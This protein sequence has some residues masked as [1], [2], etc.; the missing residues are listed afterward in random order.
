[1]EEISVNADFRL[2]PCAIRAILEQQFP[3]LRI[4]AVDLFEDGCDSV[5]VLADKTWMFLFARRKSAEAGLLRSMRLLGG[6]HADL[7][8]PV[9]RP[10]FWGVPGEAF[11]FHF[12]GYR[13]LPGISADRQELPSHRRAACA[14][15]LGEFLAALHR[16]PAGRLGA[17]GFQPAAS[18]DHAEALLTEARQLAPR[19]LTRLP[20]DLK[21]R[22]MPFLDGKVTR[23]PPPAGQLVLTHGDLQA[24]HIL[25]GP[26][27]DVC[28]IIDFG[29][30]GLSDP[31]R[32]YAGLC[33]WQGWDFAGAAL[34]ASRR[35]GDETIESRIRF[36]AKCLGLSGLA[37]ASSDDPV[38]ISACRRFLWN[39]FGD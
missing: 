32:D 23:P 13:F 39:A 17:M 27:G 35:A 29:D 10:E 20:D 36:I 38:R 1:L 19:V 34:E 16:V 24:D 37:C 2:D 5:A 33:A 22:C 7:P 12:V 3:S 30:A 25:L 4:R 21:E 15:R 8:L 26:E 11:P 6:L 31:A 14:K 9:P 18:C 28:G